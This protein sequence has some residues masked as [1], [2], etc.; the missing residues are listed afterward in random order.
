MAWLPF[1]ACCRGPRCASA[2]LVLAAVLLLAVLA[3][4]SLVSGPRCWEMA[5][6]IMWSQLFAVSCVLFT[7]VA[8]PIAWHCSNSDLCSCDYAEQNEILST[9]CYCAFPCEGCLCER[10]VESC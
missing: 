9:F 4:V 8:R 1:C 7:F 5:S 10:Y 2:A 3:L 6:W